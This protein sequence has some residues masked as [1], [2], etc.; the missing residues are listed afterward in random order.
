LPFIQLARFRVRYV[1]NIKK[2]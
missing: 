2:T 1:I